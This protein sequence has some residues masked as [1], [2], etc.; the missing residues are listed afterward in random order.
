MK[1]SL[2]DSVEETEAALAREEELTQ[3]KNSGPDQDDL[4]MFLESVIQSKENRL[5]LSEIELGDKGAQTVAGLLANAPDI[6]HV[7]LAKCNIGDAGCKEVFKVVGASKTVKSLDLSE[8]RITDISCESVI[9]ALKNN[10]TLEVLK[11]DQ[12]Q[13]KSR[14]ALNKLKMLGNVKRQ[15]II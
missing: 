1:E 3:Q 4:R 14:L 8:N 11:L 7:Q 2:L 9:T 5:E 6:E 15:L 13:I 12:N 10:N